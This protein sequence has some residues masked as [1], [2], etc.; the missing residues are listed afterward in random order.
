MRVEDNT[1]QEDTRWDIKASVY[2]VPFEYRS[3]SGLSVHV[4]EPKTQ[5]SI[6]VTVLLI[7]DAAEHAK[8]NCT[9]SRHDFK[10]TSEH[11]SS[12]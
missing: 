9:I 4:A 12:T 3:T 2:L 1:A 11:L 8:P 5:I 10:F 7:Y 6:S